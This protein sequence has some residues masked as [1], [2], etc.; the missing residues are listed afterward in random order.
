MHTSYYNCKIIKTFQTIIFAPTYFGLHKTII[1]ELQLALCQSYNID[2]NI[3]VVV[4]VFSIMAAYAAFVGT[5]KEFDI[6]NARNNHEDYSK[7]F[8]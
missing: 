3:Q 6:I 8:L 7:Y 2:C 4:E 5:N 1:R